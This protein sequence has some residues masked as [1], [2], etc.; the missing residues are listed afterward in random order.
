MIVITIILL[1]GFLAVVY[2]KLTRL[3]A[4][5]GGVI[6]FSIFKLC[7][8]SGFIL[9]AVFFVAGTLA[10]AFKKDVK[11]NVTN[12]SQRKPGQ[13]IAN[14]GFPFILS[15]LISVFPQYTEVLK[16]MIAGSFSA[17]TADTLSSEL[18]MIYGRR[19]YNIISLKEDLKGLDGVVSLEGTLLG[20]SGSTL[21]AISFLWAEGL[22]IMAIP[23]FA[24]IMG[25]V[26][27]N[28]TDS[29]MGATWE[30]RGLLGND[31]VNFLNT[32]A[33]GISAGLI[34]NYCA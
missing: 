18:G 24:I 31:G 9:M 13:V 3:A 27:G 20:I 28:L 23:C 25:G 15:L 8:F 21:I 7:G 11:E 4:V 29:L 34:F 5:A 33:G 1:G 22:R 6:A 32:V 14:A 10:T 16:L 26:I 2:K 30:R 17:A 12:E 19:F